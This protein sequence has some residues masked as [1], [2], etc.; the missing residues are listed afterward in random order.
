MVGAIENRKPPR[1]VVGKKQTRTF[2]IM[3]VSLESSQQ[4][5]VHGLGSM[6]FGLVVQRCKIFKILNDFFIEK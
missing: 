3:L 2:Q 4:R 1:N 5:G 6:T